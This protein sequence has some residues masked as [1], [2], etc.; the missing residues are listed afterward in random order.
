MEGRNKLGLEPRDATRRAAVVAHD[1]LRKTLMC[2]PSVGGT[3]PP[4]CDHR[5]GSFELLPFSSLDDDK[6]LAGLV[7]CR[8]G[9]VCFAFA[10]HDS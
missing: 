3:S 5:H 4:F 8:P 9:C 6:S 1:K 2:G 10:G 7:L